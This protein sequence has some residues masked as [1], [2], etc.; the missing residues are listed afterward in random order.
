MRQDHKEASH[1][2]EMVSREREIVRLTEALFASNA[3]IAELEKILNPDDA[4]AREMVI[5]AITEAM[6]DYPV[7]TGYEDDDA[8][9]QEYVARAILSALRQVV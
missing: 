6:E 4:G 5:A 9:A 7:A 2:M 8:V 3:R 1:K